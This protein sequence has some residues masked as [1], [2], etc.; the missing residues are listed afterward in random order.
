MKYRFLLCVMLVTLGIVHADISVHQ[1]SGCRT[2]LS[3][4][5]FPA[6]KNQLE[7]ELNRLFAQAAHQYSAPLNAHSL[8]ALIVPHAG[9]AYSGEVAASCY[10]LLSGTSVK[11]VIVLGPSHFI[12]LQGIAVPA[13]SG[14]ITPLGTL[15]VDTQA[16]Q[17]LAK[18]PFCT[19]DT[20]LFQQQEHSLEVQLPFIQHSLPG[21]SVVPV[22]VGQLTQAQ[23]RQ[24]ATALA[25]IIDA[26][27]VVVVSSDFTHY[28]KRFA[29]EPFKDAVADQI[30][31]LDSQAIQL[32]QHHELGKFI[33][34]MDATQATICG[35]KPL[36]LL[37]AIMDTHVLGAVTSHITAYA[38]SAD[39]GDGSSGR[40]SYAGVVFTT[41]PLVSEADKPL[42][43]Q[44]EK[45]AL[46]VSARAILEQAFVHQIPQ[47]LLYPVISDALNGR[48]GVF[49]T[50]RKH[51]QLRGCIGTFKTTQPLYKTVAD[52]TLKTA[53]EDTRFAPLTHK[54]LAECTLTISVLTRSHAIKSYRDIILGKNGIIL[55]QGSFTA[56]FLPEVA[57]EQQWDLPTTLTELSVKAGLP[58]QAWR[59]PSTTYEVFETVEW[60]E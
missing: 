17:R 5:W 38:S 16:V 13:C 27:T 32:M 15:T 55:T 21:C 50:L 42:F 26:S 33:Q 22:M 36:A 8:R 11:R 51:G 20:A 54:E 6:Q 23:L 14:Y 28:G 46:L 39:K 47:R 10:R 18:V 58:P 35:Y 53:F 52:M 9:Y 30:R 48:Y 45:K 19:I 7:K 12:P 1:G 49:V 44:Y 57:V 34:F 60:S 40:V 25:A 4:E 43:T 2:H 24:A 29:Y 41:Q 59:D 37:I 3:S 31:T 56:V